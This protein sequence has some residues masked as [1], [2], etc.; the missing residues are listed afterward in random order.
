[1]KFCEEENHDR[2]GGP[3]EDRDDIHSPLMREKR[4]IHPHPERTSSLMLET[5]AGFYLL[6]TSALIS[7]VGPRIDFVPFMKR[8]LM[9]FCSQ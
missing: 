9:N 4:W 3:R 5:R 8:V 7:L 2:P 6:Y 1:V